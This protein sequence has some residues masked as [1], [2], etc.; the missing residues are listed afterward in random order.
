VSDTDIARDA[1]GLSIC[2]PTRNRAHLVDD[3]IRALEP[4]LE[5][6]A[7]AVELVI[8]DNASTDD[9]ATVVGARL[10]DSL[11]LRYER[12]PEDIGPARNIWGLVEEL[13]RGEYCWVVG[14]DDLVLPGAVPA[15]LERLASDPQLDYAYVNYAVVDL[16]RRRAIADSGS[17]YTARDEECFVR[18]RT[19]RVLTRWED[20]LVANSWFPLGVYISL[21][22]HVF[23]RSAWLRHAGQ[24]DRSYGR[25]PESFDLAF[26]LLRS[27]ATMMV[28]RPTLY[29]GEPLVAQGGWHQQWGDQY[30][31]AMLTAF[32]VQL[33]LFEE[34][35]VDR[36]LLDPLRR[37]LVSSPAMRRGVARLLTDPE[38]PGRAAFSPAGFAWRNRRHPRALLG[39]GRAT[40][41]AAA[42]RVRRSLR[43]RIGST[44]ARRSSRGAHSQSTHGV[45]ETEG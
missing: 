25:F 10:R 5:Q 39:I 9:T 23:R 14:D 33:G 43:A 34:L 11:P 30:A 29:V 42:G 32:D 36:R 15:M 45:R 44:R 12:R 27:L 4:D 40:V 7:P 24:I 37:D 21:L 28:G 31:A 18:D 2:V 41:R 3:L 22:P 38:A 16:D 19:D 35:G 6:T 17:P 26:P 13:A 1:P 8:A 20:L